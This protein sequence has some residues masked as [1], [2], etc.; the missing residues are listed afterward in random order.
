[1]CQ[2]RKATHSCIIYRA[3]LSSRWYKWF[4]FKKVITGHKTSSQ[5][6]S[7]N[8]YEGSPCLWR[9]PS[10]ALDRGLTVLLHPTTFNPFI[11]PLCMRCLPEE[12]DVGY[13]K[14]LLRMLFYRRTV[15]FWEQSGLFFFSTLLW[16][17]ISDVECFQ[18]V[19]I[20]K[21]WTF[22]S[23]GNHSRRKLLYYLFTYSHP[24]NINAFKKRVQVWGRESGST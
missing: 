6:F 24:V 16:L 10:R 5:L 19:M 20:R 1:M 17:D 15:S 13:C 4:I 12:I 14:Q 11:R 21:G 18:P 22:R 9:P 3:L 8:P 23:C 2:G 7:G